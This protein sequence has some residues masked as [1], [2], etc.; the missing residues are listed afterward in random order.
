MGR[1]RFPCEGKEGLG[2]LFALVAAVALAFAWSMGAHYTGACM[3]MAYASGSI[4]LWPALAL[5]AVLA[6]AGAALASRPVGR[7]PW[8][9]AWSGRQV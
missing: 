2:T 8:A 9:W 3:G 1:R 4:R 5:M 6:W 7:S